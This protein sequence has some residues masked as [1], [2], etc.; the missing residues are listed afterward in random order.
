MSTAEP[1][2][3][4]QIF[5]ANLANERGLVMQ[6]A[7]ME[8]I[9]RGAPDADRRG[10]LSPYPPSQ[11]LCPMVVLEIGLT[12]SALEELRSKDLWLLTVEINQ[13]V[14]DYRKRVD[15]QLKAPT[16]EPTSTRPTGKHPAGRRGPDKR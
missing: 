12:K 7:L 13:A 10:D 6:S 2:N 11:N 4:K 5:A 1:K 3:E 14:L 16:P 9:K 8:N 15:V